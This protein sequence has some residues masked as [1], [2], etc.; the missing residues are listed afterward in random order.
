MVEIE[1]KTVAEF[2]RALLIT[3]PHFGPFTWYFRGQ[4]NA[5]WGL[6]PSLFRTRSWKELGGADALGLDYKG[7]YLVNPQ[8]PTL[9]A[10]ENSILR[11]L[12][13]IVDRM[14]LPLHLKSGPEREAFAQHIGLPTRLLDWTR[15]PWTAA[16]FAAAGAAP[17]FK[18]EG[19]LAVFAISS[20]YLSN[21]STMTGVQRISV[22]AAGNPNL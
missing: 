8:Q 17:S 19:K 22:G 11:M 6:V 5:K 18:E 7:D 3:E 10:Q 4:S 1:T 16:Y 15:S 20:F 2:M 14:G 21:S 13:E 9:K 12:G